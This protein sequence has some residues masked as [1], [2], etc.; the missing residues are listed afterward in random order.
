MVDFLLFFLKIACL[1]LAAIVIC[2]LAV[3]AVSR[4]FVKL[5]GPNAG[6]YAILGTSIIGTPV[7][8]FGH[9]VM[10]VIFGHKITKAVFFQPMDQ[11]GVLGYVSHSYNKKNPYHSLGNLFIGIGPIVSGLAFV[12]LAVRICFPAAF[13]TLWSGISQP[14][15]GFSGVFDVTKNVTFSLF[16][17]D[18]KQIWMKILGTFLVF[19]VC[20]HISLSPADIKGSLRSLPIYF[21][22][23]LIVSLILFFLGGSVQVSAVSALS[24]YN[25]FVLSLYSV[26][27]IFSAML[28]LI[29][30]I[31]F[32]IRKGF[33]R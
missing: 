25:I 19:F 5:V 30:L 28:L 26:V 14:A 20:L 33:S 6:K 15:N 3:D 9:A 29:A 4:L 8:E 11:N 32:V 7:H 2:G 1:P 17:N 13:D 10:C 22:I 24:V 18:G 16:K 31:I 21:I 23:A 27:F 12:L